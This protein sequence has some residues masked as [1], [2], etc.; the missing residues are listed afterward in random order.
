[1]NI[2]KKR[3]KPISEVLKM[4]VRSDDAINKGISTV[5][6]EEIYHRIAGDFVAKYTEKVMLSKTGKLTIYVKSA[7]LKVELLAQKT[8]L[9]ERINADLGAAVV[10]EIM[11][12]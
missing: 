6:I 4:Y 1:M 7:P 9:M 2:I 12:K 10:T 8:T 5:R 3:D 11:I